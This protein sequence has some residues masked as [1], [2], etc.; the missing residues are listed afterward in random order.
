ME[1]LTVDHVSIAYD[2][3][4]DFAVEDVSF[5]VKEGEYIC[6]I[7][8][9]GSGK[10]TLLKGITGLVRV[11][12]GNIIYQVKKDE[13]AYLSQSHLIDRNFPATVYEVILSGTQRQDKWTP[14]YTKADKK[15]A[16]R[17]MEMFGVTQFKDRRI[18][19][20]SGGQQQ[21]V[22]LARAFC[23]HPKLLLLDEPCAGLDP[24]MTKEFYELLDRL[25]KQEKIAIL[26]ASHD[27]DQVETYGSRVIVMNQTVEFDGTVDQWREMQER[28]PLDHE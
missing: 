20:L 9:N 19:H 7:G 11:T 23:R 22:L 8:S 16:S 1:L 4:R 14:F 17:A 28:R 25:N 21:R 12:R 5:T 2:N 3:E 10:S 24:V 13:Y 26:M 27:M 15:M 6:L 18:G